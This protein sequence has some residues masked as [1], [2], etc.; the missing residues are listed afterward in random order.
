MQRTAL[1][2]ALLIASAS[3]SA[4]PWTYHGSLNDGGK[5]ANGTY[6]LRLTLLNEAGTAS[7]SQPIT[8]Y[9][10]PVR[11]GNFSAEVEFG[12]DLSLAPALKLKTEVGQNNSGFS[13]LSEP[14]RFDP[15]AA[16]AGICWDTTGNSG[17]NANSEF[18]GTTDLNA[19]VLRSGNV[20]VGRFSAVSPTGLSVGNVIFGRQNFERTGV[21]GATIGGGGNFFLGNVVT[22]NYGVIGGGSTNMAGDDS[23]IGGLFVDGE[24]TASFATVSGGGGN[25]AGGKY[26]SVGGGL[27]NCAGGDYSSA[28]GRRAKVRRNSLLDSSIFGCS[29]V[30]STNT[31]TGD[32]GT[33]V[34]ADSQDSDFT[35]TGSNQFLVRAQ[36]GMAINTNTPSAG[37]ALTINGNAAISTTGSLGFGNQTRQMLNLWGPNDFGIGVQTGTLYSRSNTSFA[38]FQGGVHNDGYNNAGGGTLRMSLDSNGQLRTT[39]GTIATMS[40]ARLK[41]NVSDYTGALSQIAA[42]RPVYFEYKDSSQPFEAPGQHLGFIAQEVEKVF[43]QWV[44][45][46]E[47][48]Y[49]SLS[50]R[51]FEAVAVRAMQELEAEN[52]ALRDSDSAQNAELAAMRAEN[53]ALRASS[54]AQNARL[55]AL[56]KAL[57][58]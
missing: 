10:V 13:S 45:K 23:P 22:D 18:I 38:W 31:E 55:D 47:Q 54:A 51:G 42:L 19:L 57:E 4:T 33:F 2:I 39:T 35:S 48:G 14:T 5:P 30:A 9:N 49:L 21:I 58:R 34:W 20:Q 8:L 24:Q 36:G 52:A 46:D 37:A 7:V 12:I 3:V 41:K 28:G 32:Q 16:L 43:P 40:D 6:D 17:V 29:S 11:D 15:K 50:L 44:S 1:A 56:E 53:A 25:Q 27:Q 26:S